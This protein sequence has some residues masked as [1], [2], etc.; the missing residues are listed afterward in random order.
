M[1]GLVILLPVKIIMWV[2]AATAAIHRQ[3]LEML[4]PGMAETIAMW[5]IAP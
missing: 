5:T 2:L 1:L 3:R 4:L